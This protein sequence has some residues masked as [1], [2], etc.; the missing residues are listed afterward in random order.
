[1]A[2]KLADLLNESIS[3][4]NKLSNS[5]K[6]YLGQLMHDKKSYDDDGGPGGDGLKNAFKYYSEKSPKVYR[7]IYEYEYKKLKKLKV[8]DS[9]ESQSY[10]SFSESIKVAEEFADWDT[11]ISAQ[12]LTGFCYWKYMV[13]NMKELKKKDPEEFDYIDGQY[14]IESAEEEKEWIFPTN[15]KFKIVSRVKS[16]GYTIIEIK[17]I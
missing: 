12:N 9:F 2:I 6:E 1:M 8:G 10:L 17:Q 4:Y 7:G 16:R 13:A 11:I 5:D 3:A 15:I 14:A